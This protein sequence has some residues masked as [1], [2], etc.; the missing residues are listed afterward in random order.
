MIF[1]TFEKSRSQIPGLR[2]APAGGSSKI[3][4]LNSAFASQGVKAPST[5][6][7]LIE[8]Y[9]ELEAPL[10]KIQTMALSG[11]APFESYDEKSVKLLSP[12]PRPTSMR[13]GYAFRQHVE[14]A[15]K[16]RGLPMIPE[17]DQ[18][19]IFYYTNHLAVTGPGQIPVQKK[20][21]ERLDFEL[22]GA[23]VIGKS[24]KNIPASKADDFIFGYLIM[25]DWSAREL[26]TQEMKM[27]LGPAKGKDFA[28]SLGPYL[29]TKDEIASKRIPSPNGDRYDLEMK[30]FLNGK[31]I[32]TG[33]M[34]DMTWTFAQIIERISY[35]LNVHPG[36]VIGSGT[37]GTGCF[38]ELNVT[39][40]TQNVWIKP[41]DNVVMEIEA[42]G[43]LENTIVDA[44]EEFVQN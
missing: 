27:S 14:A 21:Q 39:G 19:A 1:V 30:A 10:K 31:Q 4:D 15:R 5:M 25:N 13:D 9:S 33:N 18:I 23:V 38:M 32:S 20:A 17:F 35:G 3:V 2:V 8:R 43:R 37:C 11:S 24:G 44:P 22:E 28:T 34:K 6:I 40:V 16:G 12:I 26:Q 42:L 36:E 29:V 7:E 41:G